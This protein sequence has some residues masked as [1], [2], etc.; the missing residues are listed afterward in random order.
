MSNNTEK[1]EEIAKNDVLEEKDSLEEKDPLEENDFLEKTK[2][3]ESLKKINYLEDQLKR[4]LADFSNYKK[5]IEK[6]LEQINFNENSKIIIEFLSFKE[7]LEKAIEHEQNI[8]AKKNLEELN[9]NFENILKRLNIKKINLKDTV[10]DYNFAECIQTI[11]TNKQEENNKI[12]EVIENAYTYKE[13]IIK[14]GKVIINIF[15]EE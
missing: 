6:D 11:K 8:Q 9:N 13:K 3:D 14:P 1:K 15:T 4:T 12:K 10:Y 5:R 7:I 2:E